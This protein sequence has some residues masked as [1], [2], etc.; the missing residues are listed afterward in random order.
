[1]KNLNCV[2]AIVIVFISAI[3]MISSSACISEPTGIPSPGGKV[4]V[5]QSGGAGLLIKECTDKSY[6]TQT[7]DYIVEGTVEKVES[8]WN[9]G[10]TS[11]FTNT[12]LKIE[13]YVKGSV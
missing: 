1:M 7:A 5:K 4:I 9:E 6:I 11:I 2:C 8:Q 12:D 13:N 3:L 10:R